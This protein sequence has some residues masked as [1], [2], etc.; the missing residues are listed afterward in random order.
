MGVSLEERIA[1]IHVR[2][3]ASLLRL[4]VR[5][6]KARARAA[7]REQAAAKAKLLA[8]QPERLN[9]YVDSVVEWCNTP[10]RKRDQTP[11][12]RAADFGVADELKAIDHLFRS[13]KFLA[14][15]V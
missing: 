1:Q 2:H 12:P 6:A 4:A 5:E 9:A 7:K 13:E 14:L 11:S 8:E 15:L 10:K 3:G